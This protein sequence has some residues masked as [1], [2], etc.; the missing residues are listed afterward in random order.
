M[1]VAILIM[2]KLVL[3]FLHLPATFPTLS[4][5][6]IQ[7]YARTGIAFGHPRGRRAAPACEVAVLISIV[8]SQ[9]RVRCTIPLTHN[10]HNVGIPVHQAWF[11]SCPGEK[12]HMYV[13]F[14]SLGYTVKVT[15]SR[16]RSEDVGKTECILQDRISSEFMN[17]RV[18]LNPD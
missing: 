7:L 18:V 11:Y 1:L 12:V 10:S 9:A 14:F 4:R 16:V 3:R 5:S 15:G 2:L 17:C 6:C 8:P 13:A